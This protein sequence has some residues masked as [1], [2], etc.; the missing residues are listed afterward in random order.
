MALNFHLNKAIGYNETGF[1]GPA[2]STYR[3]QAW[4]FILAGGALFANNLDYSF[5]T[6]YPPRN[7]RPACLH[8]WRRQLAFRSELKILREFMDDLNFVN[9]KPDSSIFKANVPTG[10]TVRALAEKGRAYAIYLHH[11]KP[12]FHQDDDTWNKP[13]PAYELPLFPGKRGSF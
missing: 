5:T 2:D 1:D 8:A 4:D 13:R 6:D 9:M 7:F 12:G 10:V 3:I 11:G